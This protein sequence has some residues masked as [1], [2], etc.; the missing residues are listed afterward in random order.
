MPERR[1]SDF[2]CC[3]LRTRTVSDLSQR[4]TILF[5]GHVVAIED[6]KNL[7][8]LIQH[9]SDNSWAS[10]QEIGQTRENDKQLF[11][12]GSGH[13]SVL[14]EGEEEMSCSLFSSAYYW[15]NRALH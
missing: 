14:I 13:S 8:D 11:S 5:R 3:D 2:S 10:R 12:D 4:N 15:D 6:W 1:V 9:S 7:V